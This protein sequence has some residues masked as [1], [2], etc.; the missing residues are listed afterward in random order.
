MWMEGGGGRREDYIE[1]EGISSPRALLILI[2]F[3]VAKGVHS[4]L[5]SPQALTQG[6][7]EPCQPSEHRSRAGTPPRS[8]PHHTSDLEMTAG[9]PCGAGITPKWPVSLLP[10]RE[11]AATSLADHPGIAKGSKETL[12]GLAFFPNHLTLPGAAPRPATGADPAL[13]PLSLQDSVQS[14]YTHQGDPPPSPKDCFVGRTNLLWGFHT[15]EFLPTMRQFRF[16]LQS[17]MPVCVHEVGFCKLHGQEHSAKQK[18]QQGAAE[19][20]ERQQLEAD[21]RVE[22]HWHMPLLRARAVCFSMSTIAQRQ[23]AV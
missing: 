5:T 17:K 13:Q 22:V 3:Q 8:T 23:P 18:K 21:A 20:A 19:D 15:H 14:A 7:V 4:N 10:G 12:L 9:A 6:D 1:L 2:A 11:A 16:F